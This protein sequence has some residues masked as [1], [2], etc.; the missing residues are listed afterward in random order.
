[1]KGVQ[2]DSLL[3]N[4]FTFVFVGIAFLTDK[5]RMEYERLYEEGTFFNKTISR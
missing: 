1:V 2:D 5:G 4:K 3:R